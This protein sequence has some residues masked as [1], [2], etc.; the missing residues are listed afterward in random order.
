M[1]KRQAL[2]QVDD[3]WDFLVQPADDLLPSPGAMLVTGITPQRALREGVNEAEAFA[4]IF[5][6][7]SAPETCTCL[8]YTSR[9]V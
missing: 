8:L 1:Y 7:M 2:N 3:P 9:C 5:D 4:R 6:A